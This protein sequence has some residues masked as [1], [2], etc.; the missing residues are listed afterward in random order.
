MS[1]CRR[2]ISAGSVAWLFAR[3][4]IEQA[5]LELEGVFTRNSLSNVEL[6][7][8]IEPL[9][10]EGGHPSLFVAKLDQVSFGIRNV[11]HV[12]FFLQDH[13]VRVLKTIFASA[14]G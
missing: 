14:A 3:S 7:L 6:S 11:R 5:Q 4:V 10:L 2:V 12:T 13:G 9:V 1:G 8:G